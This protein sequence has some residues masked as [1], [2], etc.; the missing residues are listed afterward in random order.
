VQA[1]AFDPAAK[2]Q[3]LASGDY[4]GGTYLWSLAKSTFNPQ[5]LPTYHKLS[6]PGNSNVE[7][8]AFSPDGVFIA[9][10]DAD[11]DTY[12]WRLKVQDG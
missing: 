7:A 4:G 11:G 2:A 8:V 9:L 6:D 3:L 5:P 1:V 12:V 10:G